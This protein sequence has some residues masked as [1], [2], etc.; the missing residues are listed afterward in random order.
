MWGFILSAIWKTDYCYLY[1]RCDAHARVSH[2]NPT[3]DDVIDLPA[4]LLRL[5][6]FYLTPVFHVSLQSE[7]EFYLLRRA[8]SFHQST[9]EITVY[10]VIH[11]KGMSDEYYLR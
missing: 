4:S 2:Y 7:T 3:I 10:I 11:K 5:A 1:F 8:Q 9:K 6:F